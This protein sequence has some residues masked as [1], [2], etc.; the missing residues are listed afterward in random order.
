[1]GNGRAGA[2]DEAKLESAT[3]RTASSGSRDWQLFDNDQ[4]HDSNTN[5]NNNDAD[6]EDE[7]SN[8]SIP[9]S[10]PGNN[11]GYSSSTFRTPSLSL[12]I[13]SRHWHEVIRN[14]ELIADTSAPVPP[15]HG[16]PVIMASSGASPSRLPSPPPFPEVQIGPQSPI[17]GGDSSVQESLFATGNTAD[18]GS[19]RRIR[20]GTKAEDMAS[21]PP[22]VPLSQVG[23]LVVGCFRAQLI[24]KSSST[25]LSNFKNTSK[26][27]TTTIRNPRTPTSSHPSHATLRSQ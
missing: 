7:L 26:L 3:E 10:I 19:T 11:Q 17:A 24:S 2:G 21:G 1:M 15:R 25:L 14:R 6:D 23:K 4:D 20:P 8:S 12:R 13:N 16:T 27:F 5:Y 18:T 9:R 22:L